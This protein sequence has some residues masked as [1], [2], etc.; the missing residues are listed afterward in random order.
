MYDI[1]GLEK[2]S[3]SCAAQV[4]R[5]PQG[6]T[7]LL[8]CC[9]VADPAT[10]ERRTFKRVVSLD[11][12]VEHIQSLLVRHHQGLHGGVSVAGWG[13]LLSKAK[14][15]ASRVA[16]ST[17]VKSLYQHVSPLIKDNVPGAKSAFAL[18]DK[19]YSTLQQA[20]QG[21]AKALGAMG[22]LRDAAMHGN[23]TAF[24]TLATMKRMSDK[25][26]QKAKSA[27]PQP[28]YRPALP[29]APATAAAPAS[30]ASDDGRQWYETG[31]TEAEVGGWLYNRG[32][33]SPAEATLSRFPG[34]GLAARGLYGRGLGR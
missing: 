32:Y 13:D 26:D 22:K 5:N 17:A 11:P 25:L 24:A 4:C 14:S 1:V 7:E 29:A 16:K 30:T 27:T 31:E 3:Q 8:V 10:G 20:R 34:V 15:I 19:A 23:K 33:R 12:L 18:A 6:H 9:V 28:W 21:Q 2:F